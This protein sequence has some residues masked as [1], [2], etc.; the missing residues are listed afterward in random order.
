MGMI[1]RFDSGEFHRT[2]IAGPDDR[3]GQARAA[4]DCRVML[5]TVMTAIMDRYERRRDYRFLDTKLSLI[6]GRDF[7]EDDP[8]RGPGTI[9][10]WIQARGLE[11]LAGHAAWLQQ[12]PDVDEGLKK[13]L[14][15][16]IL[17]A[18]AEVTGRMETLRARTGRLTF[19]MRPDGQPLRLADDGR[20]EP[21]EIPADTPTSISELFY[22]KGLAAAAQALGDRNLL[23]EAVRWFAAMQDN[24]RHDRLISDQQRLDPHNQAIGNVPGRH[25]VRM[26]PLSAATV[27]LASTGD[28]RYQ[29]LGL[30]CIDHALDRLVNTT[31]DNA[32]SRKYDMWEF[33]V[34][35][36]QPWL[37]EGGVLRCDPGHAVEFVG[38]ALKFLRVCRRQ[39]VLDTADPKRIARQL[40]LLPHIFE[41][42]FRTGFLPNG[43]GL[44]KQVDLVS[45]RILHPDVP[46]WSLPEALRGALGAAEVVGPAACSPF[47]DL[48]ARCSNAFFQHFVRS[49]LHLMAYQTLDRHGRPAGAIP[50]TP[51][52]DPGYH[53]GLSVIDGLD[54]YDRL[55]QNCPA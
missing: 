26:I 8:I 7:A 53:T 48:A 37:E 32:L 5:G 49:D 50:A 2:T 11:A 34:A 55:T 4:R 29:E 33:V 13:S 25:G 10:T 46:W 19:M 15:P 1:R 9:F 12:C 31:G 42:N 47:A 20:V 6:D 52:A 17:Q 14:G 41:Q 24:L 3:A 23:A 39:G 36:G 21:Y 16:R 30:A 45:R 35:D 28:A 38:L 18:L 22:V 40:D 44:V 27:F 54:S 51:D 43:V